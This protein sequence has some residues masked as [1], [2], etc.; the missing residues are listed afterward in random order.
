MLMID[1]FKTLLHTF[2]GEQLHESRMYK[3]IHQLKNRGY[4]MSLK[5]DIFFITAPEKT[6]SETELEELFYRK[7]LKQHCQQY[8]KHQRYL[9]ELTALEIHLHGTG[10]SI[11]EEI[12]VFNKE[13]QALET[14]MLKKKVSFKTYEAKS[15]NLYPAFAKHLQTIKLKS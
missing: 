11:P 10:V 7:L 2:F 8:C 12:I 4:L 5:K 3:L 1:D 13:K 15:K 14:V 6:P 9:G